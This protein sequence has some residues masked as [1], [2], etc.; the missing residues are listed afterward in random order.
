MVFSGLLYSLV[1]LY[2]YA[3]TLRNSIIRSRVIGLTE[4][5]DMIGLFRRIV[6]VYDFL[7]HIWENKR[8]ERAAA[9]LLIAAFLGSLALIELARQGWLPE[10]VAVLLP[11]NHFY[12]INVAFSML[13]GIEV[14]GLVFS[15][16]KSV[17]D[18]VGKQFE[19]LSLI[20]LRH[21]FQEF[22]YFKEP[23]VWEQASKPVLHILFNAGG[24]LLIFL[25]LGVYYRMQRHRVITL[26]A[27]ATAGFIASK[28][29]VS[30]LLLMIVSTV[31]VLQSY[32][33]FRGHTD[34]D[35]F[36]IFYT[37]LVFSDVLLVLISLR[38]SSSYPILFRNS[39]F[40]V[41]TVFIRLAL[42]APPYINVLLGAGAMV[43]AIGITLAYNRFEKTARPSSV[44]GEGSISP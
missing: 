32:N 40:A 9:N 27:E 19:I 20:L 35:F 33:F 36:S 43:F 15:L 39:G 14:F 10:T 5:N 44:S 7:E 25:L 21:S 16:A 18:S 3:R 8:T 37:V 42:T 23:L 11:N 29:I 31:A 4:W 34:Y 41:A 17:S 24:G 6:A 22:I 1:I 26:N 38:Y 30:L 12:A 28:K 2:F 13:L